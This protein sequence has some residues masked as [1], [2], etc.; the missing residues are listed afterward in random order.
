MRRC[1]V[2]GCERARIYVEHCRYHYRISR[3]GGAYSRTE[4]QARKDKR[5]GRFD[6]GRVVYFDPRLGRA[7]HD[8]APVERRCRGCRGWATHRFHVGTSHIGNG[9]KSLGYPVCLDCVK[10]WESYGREGR[11]VPIADEVA[12]G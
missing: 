5:G 3:H 2:T 12:H 1:T 10:L 9:G 8:L 4:Y 7:V 11:L 6:G